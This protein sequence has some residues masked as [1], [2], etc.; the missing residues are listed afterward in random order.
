MSFI[1]DLENERQN[2][3]YKT[4]II[5]GLFMLVIL[6]V[7]GWMQAPRDITLHYPP[8]LRSG[9]QMQMGEVPPF[10]VYLFAQYILQQLNSW[11]INGSKDYP[12]KVSMLR[13]YLTPNYQQ[14]LEEDISLREGN[15]ELRNRV[16][17][18]SFAPGTAYREDF[19][20]LDGDSWI[21]WL[22]VNIDEYVLGKSVKELSLR[23]PIRVVRY[24]V[25]RE[26]NPWQLALDGSG[27]FRPMRQEAKIN[28]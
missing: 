16:R 19:V 26:K 12:R 9:A 22:D 20:Q 17:N 21:V 28:E 27:K 1:S 14:Q 24:D 11:E 10:E 18:F 13:Y 25:D 5:I 2:G 15:G 3:R 4:R 6:I 8:D 7:V 23:Y